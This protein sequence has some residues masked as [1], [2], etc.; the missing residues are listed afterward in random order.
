MDKITACMEASFLKSSLSREGFLMKDVYIKISMNP[1]FDPKELI[2][3]EYKFLIE[4]TGID[5]V[6]LDK[7]GRIYAHSNASVDVIVDGIKTLYGLL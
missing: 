7:R 5:G 1:E 6:K 2:K 3:N 4:V